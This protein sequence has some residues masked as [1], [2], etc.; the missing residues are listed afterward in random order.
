[1]TPTPAI[2]GTYPHPGIPGA[3]VTAG[4][5]HVADVLRTWFRGGPARLACDIETYGLGLDMLRIKAVV[6]AVPDHVVVLDPRHPH[7]AHLIRTALQFASGIV[8]HVSTADAP[9]LCRNGLMSP[10]AIWKVTDTVIPARIA[11]PGETVPKTLEACAQRY[12]G[13]TSGKMLDTFRAL[14]YKSKTEGYANLDL[15]SP[16]YL[17]GAAA[18]GLVTARILGP[19]Q[20]DAVRHL[21]V[22]HPFTNGLDRAGAVEEIE[23]HQIK[24]RWAL[25][26]TVKGLLIDTDYRDR[27]LANVGRKRA[28][29]EEQLQRIG[30][31]PGNGAHLMRH[32][33]DQG[34]VPADHPMTKG[35]KTTPPRLSTQAKH[36]D[37]IAHPT[38]Q[39]FVAVKQMAKVADD[40]LQKC[41]DLVDD[42]GRIHPTVKILAAAHGRDSMSD[43][44]IHQF[45]GP[46]RG[47][48][49]PDP[50]TTWT[51]IDWSAQEPRIMMN[52]A[53]DTG[54]LEG[55]E[56]RGQKVYQVV[57][58][59]ADVPMKVAK[60][61]VLG[62]AYGEGI[63]KLSTDLNLPPDPWLPA[64][65]RWGRQLPARWGYQAGR[66]IQDAVWSALP[67]SK[68]WLDNGRALSQR[69]G[70]AMTVAGRI[71]PIPMGP[72]TED[73]PAG[74]QNHKWPN[75]T[76]SGSALDEQ[77]A[78]IVQA[79]KDG[80]WEYI[81]FGMHD[82]LVVDTVAADYV[83]RLMETPSERFMMMARRRPVI[84]TDRELMRE[85]WVKPE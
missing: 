49:V 46:A 47:I 76:I 22:G 3:L 30:I 20:D 28:Q 83:Q 37:T 42:E 15:D 70:V 52:L 18:D 1:L 38:A 26:Q 14:G 7:D 67:R 48:I 29:G 4:V 66:D 80:Y 72:A 55:Y 77:K 25:A 74:R 65:E 68:E 5:E 54:P 44:P 8:M 79:V 85:R 71:L 9:S 82:E 41:I 31:T 36:L 64:V 59:V 27:Y 17:F 58:D 61:A 40:Y 43:P 34:A 45:P 2:S 78:V 84:R 50:G 6:L 69:I 19:A 73:R 56:V 60:V 53:G 63:K 57:V 13:I 81:K 33:E 23:G 21:T 35:G 32:L 11:N 62:G 12:L 39:L 24:N 10:E 75:F 16:A 51:S